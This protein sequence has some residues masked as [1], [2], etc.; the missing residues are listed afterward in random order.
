ME[1]KKKSLAKTVSW[2][3]VATF[4]TFVISW[5]ITGSIAIGLGIAS[6]EFWTKLVLYY[7]HERI[8]SKINV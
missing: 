1:S 7:F 6:I 4:T 5:L 2:R 3:I 8:W